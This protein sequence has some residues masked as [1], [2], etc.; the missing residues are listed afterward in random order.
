MIRCNVVSL[1]ALT[2]AEP[3]EKHRSHDEKPNK[4]K[5]H[6]VS[7]TS[8]TISFIIMSSAAQKKLV[9]EF[10]AVTS[11]SDKVAIEA[12]NN[13]RNDLERAIDDYYSN[14]HKYS[15]LASSSSS[16]SK[17]DAKKL[18]AI[19]DK[20]ASPDDKDSMEGQQLA[21]FFTDALKVDP[22]GATPLALAWQ[23]KC[24]NFA[25]IER[26]EFLTYYQA[27]GIDT[28]SA[29]Q[30]DAKRVGQMLNDKRSFK[31]FYKWLFNHVKEEEERKTID[32]N[33]AIGLWSVILPLHFN[34]YGEWIAFVKSSGMKMVSSDLW[35]QLFEFAKD[36]K[37]D[38][39]NF[40]EDGA[41]PVSI[42]EFV[43]WMAKNKKQAS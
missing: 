28:L 10:K 33:V 2:V 12:L 32:V 39:S 35:T 21:S 6:N 17:A 15:S 40:D 36:I 20:Y 29:M 11:A 14:K 7:S 5:S 31:D 43:A 8:N 9:K 27:Q 3:A 23:Y 42:D 24:A 37:D 25:T 18:N 13:N 34:L 30:S 19:F 16:S 1:R 41:W 22:N 38:L 26:Q 4:V